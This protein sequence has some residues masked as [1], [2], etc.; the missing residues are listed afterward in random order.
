MDKITK[1]RFLGT[2]GGIML[3]ILA[4]VYIFVA[5]IAEVSFRDFVYIVIG[6]GLYA[7]LGVWCIWVVWTYHPIRKP[8]KWDQ[9]FDDLPWHKAK[10][11][12]D[13]ARRR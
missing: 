13:D 2:T 5:Y 3:I 10:K 7:I 11:E 9:Y 1:V 4:A 12:D 6:S 8:L